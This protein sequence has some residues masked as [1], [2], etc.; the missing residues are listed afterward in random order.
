MPAMQTPHSSYLSALM[1]SFSNPPQIHSSLHLQLPAGYERRRRHA[2]S[3]N[4]ARKSR[5]RTR[6]DRLDSFDGLETMAPEVNTSGQTLLVG[7]RVTGMAYIDGDQFCFV[8][9]MVNIGKNGNKLLVVATD[10]Y[11][12]QIE[13]QN[14]IYLGLADKSAPRMYTRGH[15]EAVISRPASPSPAASGTIFNSTS[16]PMTESVSPG[17]VAEAPMQAGGELLDVAGGLMA[18]KAELTDIGNNFM[19]PECPHFDNLPQE[20]NY[21]LQNYFHMIPDETPNLDWEM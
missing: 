15:D 20:P 4:T 11:V 12:L 21:M 8:G 9:D 10:D 19:W 2:V 5:Y 16:G 14:V 17:P 1:S 18:N 7:D 13:K 6:L 3:L